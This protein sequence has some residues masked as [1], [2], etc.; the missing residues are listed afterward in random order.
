M[1]APRIYTADALVLKA[2]DYGETD[3]ILTLYTAQAG[4]V[5]AIAKGVRRAKSRKAGH[6][7]LFTRANVLIARGRQLD[8]ITQAETVETFRG[9]RID[10]WRAT[11]AQYVAEL[12]DRFTVEALPGQALFSLSVNT[13]RGIADD[14]VVDLAVRLFEVQMLGLLGY[15]PQLYQCLSCN[16]SIEPVENRWSSHL[17]G[18]LCPECGAADTAALP[19]GVTALKVLRNLQTR[20]EAMRR[21]TV[22]TQIRIEVERRLQEY[23]TYRLEERP[24]STS[25]LDRLRREGLS[26]VS[27][28]SPSG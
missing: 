21:A 9:M 10:L 6:L 17:G 15:R 5:R 11:Q 13:F 7:D 2:F 18:V 19:I 1:P 28:E 20:P 24:R 26:G 12:L 14:K 3:R 16:R 8:I 22:P 23:I 25:F 27:S 4:K